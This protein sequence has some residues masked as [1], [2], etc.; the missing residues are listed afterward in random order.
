[1]HGGDS[2]A[3]GQFFSAGRANSAT[4]LPSNLGAAPLGSASR[5]ARA[6]VLGTPSIC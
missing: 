6:M 1:V 5:D 2:S 4:Q 3:A